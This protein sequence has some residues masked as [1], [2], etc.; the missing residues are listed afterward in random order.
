MS[1]IVSKRK[2][3]VNFFSETI[4]VWINSDEKNTAIAKSITSN[5]Y[6]IEIESFNWE[7]KMNN[8]TEIIFVKKLIK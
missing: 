4:K 1:I 2:K 8:R 3:K 7:S 6:F 5:E